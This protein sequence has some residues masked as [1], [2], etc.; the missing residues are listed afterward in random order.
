MKAFR[1]IVA[2]TFRNAVRSHI[3]Q[4]LLLLLL[5]CVTLIP[6][7]VSTGKIDDLIRVSLLY[8]LWSVSI[9]LTLSSLWLGCYVMSHDIDSY[10]IHMVVSKPVPRSVIWLGKWVG[11]NLINVVLLLLSGLVVYGVVMLRYNEAGEAAARFADREVARQNAEAERARIRAQILVGRR[12][13]MPELPDPAT[14]AEA[15]VNQRLQ[16]LAQEGRQFTDAEIAQLRDEI[17]RDIST[18]PIEVLPARLSADGMPLTAATAHTWVFR[19]LPTDLSDAQL[20]LRFR[21]Y[22]NKVASED[23]RE[24]SMWWA[25]QNPQT[26][27][28]AGQSGSF[29]AITPR[30][31]SYFTGEFHEHYLPSGVIAPDGTVK[32]QVINTDAQDGKHYYQIADGPQL[33]IPVCSFEVNYLRAMLVMTIQLLLLSGLACAFGGCLTMPTAIFMVVSYLLFGSLSMILT[34]TSFFISTAWD[35]LG[36]ILATVLLTVVI[37]LQ[38]FDVTDMLSGGEL[39]EFSFIWKLFF[40]YFILRG[41]PVFLL[42]IWLY[43]RREMGSAVR[44]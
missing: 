4:L 41:L 19:D 40:E 3:F 42:G 22:L 10:Q 28:S 13:F 14:V 38:N 11:I 37:P 24:S 2:L 6:F 30:P 15:A 20:I 26:V 35:K 43:R 36:N 16:E 9:V 33:L 44:K 39:I 1:A 12:V 25:V 8:S 34:D 27:E 29:I 7:S 5:L 21:P 17:K 23:Q 32:I 18:R 31:Q